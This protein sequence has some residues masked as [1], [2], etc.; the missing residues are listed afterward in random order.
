MT[1]EKKAMMSLLGRL[2]LSEVGCCAMQQRC[3]GGPAAAALPA[4]SSATHCS[5]GRSASPN[6]PASRWNRMDA[7]S[8]PTLQLPAGGDVSDTY[9]ARACSGP[10]LGRAKRAIP[11]RAIAYSS[12]GGLNQN[13]SSMF[14]ISIDRPDAIWP[15]QQSRFSNLYGKLPTELRRHVCRTYTGN[16]PALAQRLLLRDRYPI[17]VVM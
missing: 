16:Q 1:A 11:G 14:V 12:P 6:P 2:A 4:R 15:A 8:F 17:K 3:S 5:A 13:A 7:A 10:E 9:G